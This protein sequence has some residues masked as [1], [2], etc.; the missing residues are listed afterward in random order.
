MF[1]YS[2][3]SLAA[4][5]CIRP[6]QRSCRAIS[7]RAI[8]YSVADVSPDERYC[9]AESDGDTVVRNLVD[10]SSTSFQNDTLEVAQVCYSP[11]GKLVAFASDLGYARVFDTANWQPV[12]TLRG[13]LQGVH[14]VAF[15]SDAQRL[16]TCSDRKE[17]LMLWATDS[18]QNVL[19]LEADGVAKLMGGGAAF[20][21]DGNVIGWLSSAGDLYFWHAPSRDQI[22]AAEAKQKAI[23]GQP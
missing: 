10:K 13:F 7:H 22:A 15:S 19:A 4:R 21:P 6:W 20:S 12:V 18:W 14:D 5:S 16:L 9:L 11:D 3:G 23:S 17:A 2:Y 8:E 1:V